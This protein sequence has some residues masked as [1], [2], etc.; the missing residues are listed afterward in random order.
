METIKLSDRVIKAIEDEGFSLSNITKQDGEYLAELNQHTPEDED[1]WETI[2]F[3]G[4][5]KGFTEAIRSRLSNFDIDEEAEMWISGRGKNGIPG[6][7]KDLIED[8]EWKQKTLE[9]LLSKLDAVEEE[10]DIQ[11]QCDSGDTGN[12]KR[13]KQETIDYFKRLAYEFEKKACR[14]DDLI[15]K[16]KSEAYRLAAFE[17]ERNME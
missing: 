7:I 10:V 5:D 3:D 1:W 8:A 14:E 16:G 11:N 4:T 12:S 13:T 9:G 17:I 6:S 2:W 15:A